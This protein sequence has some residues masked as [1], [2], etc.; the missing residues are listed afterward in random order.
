VET[1]PSNLVRSQE[2]VAEAQE[3]ANTPNWD[4]AVGCTIENQPGLVL[5]EAKANRPELK[6]DGK[7]L[8][9]SPSKNSEEN[10][11]QVGR[12]IDEARAGWQQV[13]PRVSISRDSHHQLAN[14]LAFTW[15]LATL[16]IPVVLIYLGFIGDEGIREDA[17]APFSD[18]RDWQQAFSEYVSRTI[19]LDFFDR[20]VDFRPSPVWLV[21]RSRPI[22]E[23]SSPFLPESRWA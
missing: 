10:H 7:L 20:R 4:I 1:I 15:K 9:E 17:G 22:L 6:A 16:G 14:R 3:G 5:V 21:S 18:D 23:Q 12:A 11:K 19:P 8:H 13:D 2:L